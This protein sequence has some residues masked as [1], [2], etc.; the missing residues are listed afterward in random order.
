M[1]NIYRVEIR[2]TRKN[3]IFDNYLIKV[4]PSELARHEEYIHSRYPHNSLV[5][6]FEKK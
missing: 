1:Q 4:D 3:T 6:S 5:V 2:D